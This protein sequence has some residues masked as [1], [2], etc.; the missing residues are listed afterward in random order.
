[1]THFEKST[2]AALASL[3]L[4]IEEG[5][6]PSHSLD[7]V[8]ETYGYIGDGSLYQEILDMVKDWR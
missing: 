3:H 2:I 7:A 6:W 5:D 1:M 8:L 4:K